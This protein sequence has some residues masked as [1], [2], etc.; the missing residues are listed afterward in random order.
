M[1]E[2]LNGIQEVGSSILPGSTINSHRTPEKSGV[3]FF[4]GIAPVVADLFNLDFVASLRQ[5]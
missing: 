4:L 5:A 3:L 1:G 2:R